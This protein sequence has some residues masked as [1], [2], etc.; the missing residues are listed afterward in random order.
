MR[1]LIQGLIQARAVAAPDAVALVDRQRQVSYGELADLIGRAARGFR[2]LGLQRGDRVAVYLEKRLETVVALF[3]T[4]AAGGVFV[5]INPQL[6]PRQGAHLPQ[7]SDARLLVTAAARDA[8]LPP[9]ATRV[10]VDR[11][12]WQALLDGGGPQPHAV[13]DTD[14]AAILYT[15]GSTGLPKGVV[16][17]H[18]HP[19]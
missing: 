19:P 3:A 2:R 6:K 12:D 8:L 15:S 14:M 13:I 9:G 7:D 17:S 18:R 16:L 10:L 5:P 1:F 4:A 11:P